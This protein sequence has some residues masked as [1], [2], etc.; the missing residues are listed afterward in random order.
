MPLTHQRIRHQNQNSLDEPSQQVFAKQ[1][2]GLNGFTETDFV[3]QQYAPSKP[4][5]HFADRFNLMRQMLD[6]CES[7]QTQ[8]FVKSSQQ[9]QPGMR[10]MQQKLFASREILRRREFGKVRPKAD[11]NPAGTE[12]RSHVG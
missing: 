12:R 5:H 6:A 7:V 1:Q 9:L 4:P 11:W 2:A 10:E 8:Q 3:C